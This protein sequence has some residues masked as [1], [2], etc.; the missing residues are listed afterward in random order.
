MRKT[1]GFPHYFDLSKKL[2]KYTQKSEYLCFL[3]YNKYINNGSIN[4]YEDY[5]LYSKT[6]DEYFVESSQKYK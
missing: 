3:W 2:F 6:S 4:L 5:L 1:E